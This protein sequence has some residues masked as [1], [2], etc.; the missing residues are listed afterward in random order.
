MLKRAVYAAVIFSLLPFVTGMAQTG[1]QDYY[2]EY[3]GIMHNGH[4]WL[5]LSREDSN[6][7]VSYIDSLR[8]HSFLDSVEHVS[9]EETK[10]RTEYLNGIF[11]GEES[12]VEYDSAISFSHSQMLLHNTIDSAVVAE[13]PSLI[14]LNEIFFFRNAQ[15]TLWYDH[16]LKDGYAVYRALGGA[17]GTKLMPPDYPDFHYY[18]DLV[19]MINKFYGDDR[20]VNIPIVFASQY[21]L[22]E[23]T[24]ESRK[25]L[26]VFLRK[27]RR[28]SDALH[29]DKRHDDTKQ[30]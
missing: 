25:E 18:S 8:K 26:N 11:D 29:A 23:M 30:M 12:L 19:D 13:H 17:G 7:A 9:D 5:K 20:N 21:C 1:K 28:K 4:Y 24:G 3:T 10:G 22:R 27:L 15:L 16:G 14:I 2:I 6:D